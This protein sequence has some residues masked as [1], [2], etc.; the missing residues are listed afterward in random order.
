MNLY[1]KKNKQTI[2]LFLFF[3]I[4]K[5]RGNKIAQEEVLKY[6]GKQEEPVALSQ[7]YEGIPELNPRCIRKH[8]VALLKFSEIKCI[9]ID[10]FECK[11]RF[12]K[13]SRR[14]LLYYV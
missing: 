9:E 11:R 1:R 7:I 5:T 12:K 4:I 10:R 6:L 8:I 3:I 13:L 2:F 14:M